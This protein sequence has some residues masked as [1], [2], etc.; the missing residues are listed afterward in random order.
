MLLKAKSKVMNLL[1]KNGVKYKNLNKINGNAMIFASYGTR[2][3]KNKLSTYK[4]LDSLG[5]EANVTTNKGVNPLH[6]I[7]YKN[8]LNIIKYFIKN[9]VNVNQ[10]NI[11][12]YN[13]LMNS[14]YNNDAV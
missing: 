8:N 14:C 2:S 11:K 4:Y 9:G 5:I 1:I 6:A 12:G 3:S 13:V 10:V 7:V